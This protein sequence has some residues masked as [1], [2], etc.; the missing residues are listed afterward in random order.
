MGYRRGW[1]RLRAW[2]SAILSMGRVAL[3]YG[4][5]TKAMESAPDTVAITVRDDMN[6]QQKSG[7]G[8]V[9]CERAYQNIQIALC[10]WTILRV[11]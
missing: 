1:K 9:V 2:G 10:V 7:D 11:K 6:G 5:A 8:Q 3:L 4:L